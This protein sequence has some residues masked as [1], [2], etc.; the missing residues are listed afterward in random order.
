LSL[1]RSIFIILASLVFSALLWSY[2]RLSAAYESDMDLPARVIAPKGY[3]LA[4]G[5]P[6][7]LHA[8]VRGA[9]WQIMLMNF[10]SNANFRFDLTE[11]AVAGSGGSLI[12]KSDEIANAAVLPSELRVLKVEPDSLRLDFSKAIQK[13]LTV[14]PHV[15]VKPAKGFVLGM[16]TIT[17]AHILVTGA[18]QV[19]DSIT[20]ISTSAIEVNNAKEP[21]DQVVQISDS[22]ENFITIL[23]A[24][25]I[26]VHVNVEPIGERTISMVPV[27]IDAL[28]PDYELVLSPSTVSV[29]I[30][31][32]VDELAKIPPQSIHARVVYDPHYFDTA[33]TIAPKVEVP[34]DLTYLNTEPRALR[35]I[36]RK[37]SSNAT[38]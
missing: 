3:A 26:S 6:S 8:R 7:H 27:A 24:P 16:T 17:P 33:H 4:S 9:G 19:L 1:T 15:E 35:F 22:L 20:S 30:R 32:G 14:L 28:P 29:T 38:P 12:L 34:K 5:L 21:V 37:R 18:P 10:T 25:K 11:R 31:G 23:N 13:E 2:V 36:V